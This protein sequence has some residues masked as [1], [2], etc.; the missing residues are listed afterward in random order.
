MTRNETNYCVLNN[1]KSRLKLSAMQNISREEL[2]NLIAA[3]LKK[4]VESNAEEIANVIVYGE[5]Y[6]LNKWFN[7]NYANDITIVGLLSNLKLE[8]WVNEIEWDDVLSEEIK[9]INE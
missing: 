3:D 5:G 8:N 4:F 9:L 2:L 7:D 6:S 1:I